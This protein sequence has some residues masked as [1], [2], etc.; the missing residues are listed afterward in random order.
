M[1]QRL[2]GCAPTTFPEMV[3]VE[4]WSFSEYPLGAEI[5]DQ[6]TLHMPSLVTSFTSDS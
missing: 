1:I 3:P 4:A 2:L 6:Y 5:H